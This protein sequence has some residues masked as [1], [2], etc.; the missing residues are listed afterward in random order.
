MLYSYEDTYGGTPVLYEVLARTWCRQRGKHGRSWLIQRLTHKTLANVI[1]GTSY[2]PS[3]VSP[4]CGITKSL[5]IR[6]YCTF[7]TTRP[8]RPCLGRP[9]EDE[10]RDSTI[11]DCA[12]TVYL[13]TRVGLSYS[14]RSGDA[15]DFQGAMSDARYAWRLLYPGTLA[16]LVGD[17]VDPHP[18][19]FSR[20]NGTKIWYVVRNTHCTGVRTTSISIPA[21]PRSSNLPRQRLARR[22]RKTAD[23]V[24]QLHGRATVSRRIRLGRGGQRTFGH[25][26]DKKLG[27]RR[28]GS[29]SPP[30][31]LCATFK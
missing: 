21:R 17:R 25:C 15:Q 23:D 10:G 30:S 19:R 3:K 8:S 16:R 27:C 4:M 13:K 12:L 22:P 18:T 24:I 31:W 11:T 29:C 1:S 9:R 28:L 5:S 6:P 26:Q 2:A 20:S 14:N 7:R